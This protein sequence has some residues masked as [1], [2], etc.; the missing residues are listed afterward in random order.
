MSVPVPAPET[1]P[2]LKFVQIAQNCSK[3]DIKDLPAELMIFSIQ[4]LSFDIKKLIFFDHFKVPLQYRKVQY[5]L[6]L[7]SNLSHLW[8]LDTTEICK[9]I[10]KIFSDKKLTQYLC[11]EDE[12]FR[13]LWA[14]RLQGEKI[15]YDCPQREFI[16]NWSVHINEWRIIIFCAVG[17]SLYFVIALSIVYICYFR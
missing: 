9:L 8:C 16:Y 3:F 7:K 1:I 15:I 5:A 17:L 10:P 13:R 14:G 11:R 6:N 4:G 12:L 2:E